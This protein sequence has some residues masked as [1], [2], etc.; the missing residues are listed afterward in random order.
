M[1]YTADNDIQEHTDVIQ[2]S[3]TLA[4]NV[5]QNDI[6]VLTAVTEEQKARIEDYKTQVKTLNSEISRLQ[7]VI[8]ESPDPTELAVTKKDNEGLRLV[9]EEKDRSIERLEKEV[10]RLDLFSHYF[11]SNPVRQIEASAAER[12]K[13]WYKFW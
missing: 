8:M 11:K 4:N 12:K 10:N 3:H 13:P 1:S 9:I 7:N 2:I 5:V 6:Q